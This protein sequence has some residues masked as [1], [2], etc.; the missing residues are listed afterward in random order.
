[1]ISLWSALYLVPLAVI[2]G[3]T[4]GRKDR[5][6]IIITSASAV[7]YIF[8]R[9]ISEKVSGDR[10]F[11]DLANDFMVIGVMIGFLGIKRPVVLALMATYAAMIYFSYIP[12]SEGLLTKKGN[13]INNE[14]IG[15]IQ[16]IILLL[17]VYYHEFC[18]FCSG[19]I[20]R[21]EFVRASIRV[22]FRIP[23]MGRFYRDRYP[24]LEDRI[25]NRNVPE[26]MGSYIDGV[27]DKEGLKPTY[28]TSPDNYWKVPE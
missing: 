2:M 28:G 20:Q 24:D 16:L 7:A 25:R 17:G 10:Y 12:Y 11:W 1:M 19:F 22:S 5:D 26:N 21:N 23:F 8:T 15:K 9:I 6:Y 14:I 4:I 18:T 13:F 27:R 3:I